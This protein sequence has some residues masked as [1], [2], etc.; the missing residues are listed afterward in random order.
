[1]RNKNYKIF[2]ATI[3]GKYILLYIALNYFQIINNQWDCL[4]IK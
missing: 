1:M 3:N 2:E 4:S